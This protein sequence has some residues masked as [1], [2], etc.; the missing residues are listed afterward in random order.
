[1]WQILIEAGPDGR[2][3]GKLWDQLCSD[4]LNVTREVV[5]RWLA[6]G[7]QKG[8]VV[9]AGKPWSRWVWVKGAR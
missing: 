3:A 4:G 1:M 6:A 9:R 7:E 2:T 8:Y 5:Q